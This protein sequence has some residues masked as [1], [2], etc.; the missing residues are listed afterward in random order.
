[1][2]VGAGPSGRASA[3]LLAASLWLVLGARG[4]ALAPVGRGVDGAVF[5]LEVWSWMVARIRFGGPAA[6]SSGAARG[7]WT[8]VRGDFGLM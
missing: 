4:V 5:G 6:D 2:G 3:G 1:M 8:W 7:V